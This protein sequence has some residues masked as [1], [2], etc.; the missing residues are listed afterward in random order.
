MTTSNVCPWQAFPAQSF[1]CDWRLS[2]AMSQ[3]L[4]AILKLGHNKQQTS[5]GLI[6]GMSRKLQVW[7]RPKGTI[8]D[9]PR[10]IAVLEHLPDRLKNQLLHHKTFYGCN[11]FRNVLKQC[12]C[13]CHLLFIRL[14][15]QTGFL[16][17]GINYDRKKCYD[18]GPEVFHN[19]CLLCL[20]HWTLHFQGPVA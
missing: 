12:F 7:P 13:N 18:T 20:L 19:I 5:L 2:I 15:K 11:K 4:L 10:R 1:E 3:F 8:Q 9:S 6:V 16:H 17:Y 14:N